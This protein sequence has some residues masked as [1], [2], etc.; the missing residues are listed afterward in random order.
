MKLNKCIGKCERNTIE[1]HF[2]GLQRQPVWA[3]LLRQSRP[4]SMESRNCWRGEKLEK[5]FQEIIIFFKLPP[6]WHFLGE[7]PDNIFLRNDMIYIVSITSTFISIVNCLFSDRARKQ[8]V[9]ITKKYFKTSRIKK[10][11]GCKLIW[12]VYA[13]ICPISNV[14]ATLMIPLQ[15]L[16]L[17][18][19]HQGLTILIACNKN[20]PKNSSVGLKS[21]IV[22][23][24]LLLDWG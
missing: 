11:K 12:Y 7:K 20:N 17:Y 6:P 19:E 23:H 15:L 24:N 4:N 18:V 10:V 22:D 9:L 2:C 5:I 8:I 21:F 14:L 3:Q 13:Q 16:W 1:N